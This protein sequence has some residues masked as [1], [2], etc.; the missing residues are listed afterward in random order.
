MLRKPETKINGSRSHL[1][2]LSLLVLNA[3]CLFAQTKPVKVPKDANLFYYQT[4]DYGEQIDTQ[5]TVVETDNA[6]RY[7]IIDLDRHLST[8]TPGYIPDKDYIQGYSVEDIIVSELADSVYTLTSIL[9]NEAQNGVEQS[10]KESYLTVAPFSR[11]DIQFE[12]DKVGGLTRYTCSINSNKLEFYL[13]PYSRDITPCPTTAASKRPPRQLLAQRTVPA[14]PHQ[15]RETCGSKFD[16]P[17]A[18]RVT[19]RELN[20][21]KRD[22]MVITTRIFDNVQLCWG[23][24]N[25]HIKGDPYLNLP[26][27]TVL[28]F[29]GGTLALKRINLPRLPSHYQTF[30]EIHQRSNGDAYDRTGSLFVVPL[31]GRDESFISFF[32]GINEHPDSLPTITDRE[33]RRYQGIRIEGDTTPYRNTYYPPSNS[34]A[35]SPPSA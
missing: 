6:G 14:L 1:V 27:D 31:D 15:S 21:I 22:R 34:C 24:Q 33:G 29:A 32:R 19:G 26:E 35:S 7:L 11:S 20:N 16:I 23:K 2:L 5:Y 13:Q 18:Q 17:E 3:T 25:S 30:V 10:G 4:M 12:T 8:Y 9:Y 28:H